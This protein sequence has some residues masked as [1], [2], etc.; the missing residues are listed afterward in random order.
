MQYVEFIALLPNKCICWSSLRRPAV[1]P[2]TAHL[3]RYSPQSLS[4]PGRR[5]F[6]R[7]HFPDNMIQ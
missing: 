6:F 4:R 3:L 5:F 2:I 1:R 7:S